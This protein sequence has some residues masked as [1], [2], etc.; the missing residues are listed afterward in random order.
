MTTVFR[1]IIKTISKFFRSVVNLFSRRPRYLS[2]SPDIRIVG[3]RRAGKTTFMAAL[4]RWPNARR[5]S[6]IE[7]V[8]PFD[9]RTDKLIDQ[10]KDILENGLPLAGTFF[11]EDANELPLYTLLIEMKPAFRI[12]GN[13]KFQVSCRD[14]PGK[15]I[16]ELRKTNITPKLSNYLDDCADATGLLLLID[17]TAREDKLYSQAFERL[18]EELNFRLT[19]QNKNLNSYRIAV[20]FSKAEQGSVW[21]HRHDMQKFMRLKFS[22]TE[23]TL[24]KW[25]KEWGCPMNY[26]FCSA[27][28][29]IGEPLTPNFREE[30]RDSGAIC[31]VINYPQYWR[32]FGLVAPIYWLH[33][34]KDDWRLRKMEDL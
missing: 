33:T 22:Q 9:D 30:T 7:S 16:E 14:Y 19:G 1:K 25:Q 20:A 4:A 8:K 27:F 15:L 31:G 29:M 32:P 34:G 12:G 17:G 21:I 2:G 11:P 5:D 6:P 28:G 26:F 10:A 24:Q 3:H 18:K 23:T 13:I